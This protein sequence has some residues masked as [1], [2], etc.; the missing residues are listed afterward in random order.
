MSASGTKRTLGNTVAPM[1]VC[2]RVSH[3]EVLS[4]GAGLRQPVPVDVQGLSAAPEGSQF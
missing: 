3:F 4:N 1:R 2:F